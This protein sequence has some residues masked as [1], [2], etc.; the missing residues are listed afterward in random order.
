[1]SLRWIH[2]SPPRWD[3]Q[4]AEI[5]GRAP[6]GIFKLGEPAAGDL[7]PGE[8]W[9]VEDEGRVAGFGW[10]DATWGEAEILLAV[11]PG[12]QGRGVGAFILDR[13]EAEARE[14]GLNYLYNVVRREHPDRAGVTA[15]LE[16]HRFSPS[17]DD[18]R[19]VRQ[20]RPAGS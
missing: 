16:R 18:D 14:R 17:H 11:A 20:V 13:L 7:L 12:S 15:W 5:V 9:H 10:M 6:A 4:K 2:E 19:L 8:W 3:A 1:M